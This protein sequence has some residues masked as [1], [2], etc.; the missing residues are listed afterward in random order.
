MDNNSY[1]LQLGLHMAPESTFVNDSPVLVEKKSKTDLLWVLSLYGTAI[2]AG[3]LFLPINAGLNGLG[4]L[5]IL[6]CLAFPMTF[7]SHRALCRFVLSSSSQGS[8]ITDV[9]EEHFGAKA[10]K[11]LTLLYFF[12]IF[13][14]MLLYSVAITNTT[15]SFITNQLGFQAPPRAFL[16]AALILALMGIIRVG[17]DFIL[18]TLKFL[19]YPFIISLICLSIFL[20]PHWNTA[21]LKVGLNSLPQQSWLSTIWLALPVMVFAF[22]HT[23]IISCFAVEQ[24]KQFGPQAENKCIDIL[25]TSHILMVTTVM[26]FVFSC[27]FCLSPAE[28]LEAKKQ[29]ISILSYLA[30]H[31][32]TPLIAYIAPIIAFIAIAK[33]YL[34]HYMGAREGLNGFLSKTSPKWSNRSLKHR[35]MMISLFMIFTCWITATLN[36]NILK[37]IEMLSGPII[38]LLLFLMPMYAI[39]T[40][41]ALQQYQKPVSNSFI[42]F[43]GLVALSSIFY[44]IWRALVG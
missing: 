30:N 37:I 4:P 22:N 34:G 38:A 28:L 32:H 16:S 17:Q 26:C 3:T 40:I 43:I 13:P 19:V 27:V 10:G 1:I 39:R 24:K 5:L 25:K 20:I 6:A 11:I 35:E 14:V 2:G 44:G 8:N 21:F 31:F 18:K 12:S 23:S 29:N 9:V 42:V 33:S 36:P 7:F 41:P 15:S